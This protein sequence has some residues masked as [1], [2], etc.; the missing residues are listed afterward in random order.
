M[1]QNSVSL[2]LAKEL[3][4]TSQAVAA[5]KIA[6]MYH[7]R[8]ALI[9][10]GSDKVL[11]CNLTGIATPPDNGRT[12]P[13]RVFGEAPDGTEFEAYLKGSHLGEKAFPYL[14][15][16]EWMAARLAK[17]LGLPCALPLQIRL[18][19]DVVATEQN[20]ALRAR[21]QSGPEILFGSLNSGPGWSLW[22]DATAVSRGHAHVAAEIYFFDTLI[23]NWDR[24][25]ANPNL[26]VKGDKFLMIDHGEAFVEATGSEPERDM[27]P[28][29]WKVGGV[30]NHAGEYE[31]HP[32]WSK[33]RP[34][35]R[36]RF[37]EVANRWRALPADMFDLIAADVPDCW[38]K[39]AS[40]RIA[41]YLAEAVEKVDKIVANIEYNFER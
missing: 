10:H 22:T 6:R 8:P 4:L 30:V 3:V 1:G 2:A 18:D 27:T 32:L 36:I 31:I 20:P 11:I 26:L 13:L 17:Q 16:R 15:E 23:Q 40:L 14:M 29:P 7:R 33:L 24:C 9:I 12:R 34:K 28:L 38:S 5:C 41:A 21:L 25:A 19:P 39:A 35:S 37:T